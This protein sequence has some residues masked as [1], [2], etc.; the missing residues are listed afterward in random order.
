MITIKNKKKKYIK[1]NIEI[2]KINKDE[3]IVTSGPSA[4]SFGGDYLSGTAYKL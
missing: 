2:I 1:P 3:I 4:N